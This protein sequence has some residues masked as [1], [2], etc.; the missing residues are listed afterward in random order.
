MFDCVTAPFSSICVVIPGDLEDLSSW[1]ADWIFANW[2]NITFVEPDG[3]PISGDDWTFFI[4]S[5]KNVN[6]SG[7]T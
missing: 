2:F 5:C 7:V 6:C 3:P 1:I 4:D